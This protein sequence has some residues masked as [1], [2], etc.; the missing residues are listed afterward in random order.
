MPQLEIDETN[1]LHQLLLEWKLSLDTFL[2]TPTLES[3]NVEF[4]LCAHS[5]THTHS[6]VHVD[7]LTTRE[8]V[9][10]KQ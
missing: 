10:S 1:F 3:T 8:R 5:H 7:K 6:N 9:R 4:T 2:T